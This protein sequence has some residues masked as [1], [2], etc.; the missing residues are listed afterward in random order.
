[1]RKNARKATIHMHLVSLTGSTV[2]AIRGPKIYKDK[3]FPQC[4]VKGLENPILNWIDSKNSFSMVAEFIFHAEKFN[5]I[6]NIHYIVT[7]SS[8]KDFFFFLTW[9]CFWKVKH[10]YLWTSTEKNKDLKRKKPQDDRI[11]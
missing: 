9:K 2:D 8:L 1:M 10:I 6:F 4:R 3:H 11:H 5:L 7:Q